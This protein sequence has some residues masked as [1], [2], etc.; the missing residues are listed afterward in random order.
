MDDIEYE[1]RVIDS[2]GEV[3]EGR[4]L[5]KAQYMVSLNT[6]R[7][8]VIS[9]RKLT[10]ENPRPQFLDLIASDLSSYCLQGSKDDYKVLLAV[11]ASSSF[12]LCKDILLTYLL[13]CFC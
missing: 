4:M 6:V 5:L 2:F 9:S 12:L 10:L 11:I 7:N 13:I 8:E 3:R 1:K